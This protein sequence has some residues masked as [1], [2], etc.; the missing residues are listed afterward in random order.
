MG[1]KK[2]S[3]LDAMLQKGVRAEK[4]D[5]IE[6]ARYLTERMKSVM[7]TRRTRI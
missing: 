2:R 4:A 6:K 5:E 1:G 7:R 3:L